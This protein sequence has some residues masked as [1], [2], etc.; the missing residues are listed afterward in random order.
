ML[1]KKKQ[2]IIAKTKF[3]VLGTIDKLL[4]H[5]LSLRGKLALLSWLN[6]QKKKS[7]ENKLTLYKNCL[8]TS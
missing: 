5:P 1:P 6:S 7:K 2:I 3:Y 8:K 4:L